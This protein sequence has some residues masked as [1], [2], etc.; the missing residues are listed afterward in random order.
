MADILYIVVTI[1]DLSTYCK[2]V[3]SRNFST[4]YADQ[5]CSSS[6]T[7]DRPVEH[8][9]INPPS[10]SLFPSQPSAIPLGRIEMD[11]ENAGFDGDGNNWLYLE[12]L[13]QCYQKT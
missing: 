3:N 6:D 4:D 12:S 11:L 9:S 5:D 13:I 8:F 10:K 1:N 2:I 7:D